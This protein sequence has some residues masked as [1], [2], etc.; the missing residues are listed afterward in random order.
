MVPTLQLQLTNLLPTIS[1]Q[2]S[3]SLEV[4]MG[5]FVAVYGASGV[6]K[7][8]FLRCLAGLQVAEQGFIKVAGQTWWDQAAGIN[9]SA[10][11]RGVGF[12]FQ[13]YALFPNMTV[14]QNIAFATAGGDS[15]AVVTSLL[16]DLD[17]QLYANAYPS[18]LSGGQQQRLA[19][20][21][22]LAQ[23]PS[24]LLLDEPLAALDPALRQYLQGY[25]KAWQ[26]KHACTVFMVS[27]QA[28]EIAQLADAILVLEGATGQ[29]YQPVSQYFSTTTTIAQQTLEAQVQA[30]DK[31]FI[32]V[33]I[34]HQSLKIPQQS[35]YQSLSIG[36]KISLQWLGVSPILTSKTP[37]QDDKK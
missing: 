14:A 35:Q 12:V 18:Q 31:Q 3:I 27:H 16:H 4:A 5:S 2:L 33:Q 1:K 9:W 37:K 25:L 11:K 22:A 29:F 28:S 7:T 13:D 30:I 8:S 32:W 34:G 36:E 24:I 20:A 23:A 19:L 17:L 10:R 15:D 26:Q 6:G 21:R